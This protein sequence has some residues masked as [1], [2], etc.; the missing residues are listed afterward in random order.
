[1]TPIAW[2][3]VGGGEGA[4]IG[5]SHRMA[6][7]LDGAFALVAGVMSTDPE[8]ALRSAAACGIAPERS[9]RDY[10]EMARSEAARSDGIRAVTIVTPNVSHAAIAREF[11]EAGIDVICDKPLATTRAD[12][13]ALTALAA[14]RGRLLGVTFNYT[15]YPLMREARAMVEAGALG[16]IRIVQVEFVLGWL[17]TAMEAQGSKQAAWRTDPAQSGPSFVVMDIGT[18]AAHLAGFVTGLALSEVAADLTTFVEGRKLE[19]HAD[20]L[21]RYDGGARGH[22][23]VSMVAAGEAAGF[24]LR[25]YGEKGHIAWDQSNPDRMTFAPL[26]GPAQTLLRGQTASAAARGASRLVPGLPEGYLEAFANLYRDYAERIRTGQG[27]ELCPQG[28]DGIETL[29]FVEA[30]LQSSD[31]NGSWAA[32]AR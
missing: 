30:V 20:V 1:M 14:A 22:L 8:R 31:Q 5:E 25:V 10:R 28:R 19:D 26:N 12:A 7:R 3:M 4:F 15:G 29:A 16:R 11:L 9:Y 13:Q 23:W 2:G 17:S 27:G 6:A 24:R 21:L 18:H 32:V